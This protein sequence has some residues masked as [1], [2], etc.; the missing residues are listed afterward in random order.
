MRTF[1]YVFLW[2]LVQI[3]TTRLIPHTGIL[4]PGFVDGHSHPVFAGDR[5]HEF[6]M[7]LAGATYMEVWKRHILLAPA[8]FGCCR[9]KQREVASTSRP[10][11]RE[12]QVRNICWRSSRRYKQMLLP[13][14]IPFTS[15]FERDENQKAVPTEVVASIFCSNPR[16][17]TIVTFLNLFI[18]YVTSVKY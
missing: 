17:P 7:K 5:V 10:R 18:Q 4:L 1:F 3:Y 13:S 15:H 6:A 2:L 9:F 12:R 16:F 14:L 8:S 11:R